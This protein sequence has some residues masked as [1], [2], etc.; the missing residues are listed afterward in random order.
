MKLLLLTCVTDMMKIFQSSCDSL[1]EKICGTTNRKEVPL[2][3]FINCFHLTP[4]VLRIFEHFHVINA[5]LNFHLITG[6][7]MRT[8][9]LRKISNNN[10]CFFYFLLH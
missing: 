10:I 8:I 5:N 1:S 4:A 6:E 9:D 2:D 7:C 3:R